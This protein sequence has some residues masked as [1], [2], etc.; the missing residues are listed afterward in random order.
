MVNWQDA[1]QMEG[2][3]DGDQYFVIPAK[4][5]A[6]PE[7]WGK[8]SRPGKTSKAVMTLNEKN[9]NDAIVQLATNKLGIGP[10]D[11]LLCVAFDQYEAA[12]AKGNEQQAALWK[13]NIQKLQIYV[14]QAVEGLKHGTENMLTDEDLRAMFGRDVQPHPYTKLFANRSWKAYQ[15]QST[16]LVPGYIDKVKAEVNEDHSWHPLHGIFKQIATL[17]FGRVADVMPY[18]KAV[19]N[20]KTRGLSGMQIPAAFRDLRDIYALYTRGIKNWNG[21]HNKNVSFGKDV[22]TPVRERWEKLLERYAHEET[23]QIAD[24]STGEKLWH[25][26]QAKVRDLHLMLAKVAYEPQP[27]WELTGPKGLYK[28]IRQNDVHHLSYQKSTVVKIRP[29]ERKP[30]VDGIISHEVGKRTI[31]VRMY[32]PRS[33]ALFHHLAEDSMARE[34]LDAALPKISATDLINS[35]LDAIRIR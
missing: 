17:E 8:P 6:S 1:T 19:E 20:Q 16:R 33:G 32:L 10:R 14:Q 11:Y 23:D 28:R 26:N 22:L 34:I 5:V 3:F 24:E 35:L 25:Y 29:K 2:D 15:L 4:Y 21:G 9:L 18:W 30:I 13:E 27:N 7:N 12:K 31:K